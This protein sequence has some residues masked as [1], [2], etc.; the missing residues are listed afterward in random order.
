MAAPV[1][2]VIWPE[3]KPEVLPVGW[4]DGYVEVWILQD[5]NHKPVLNLQR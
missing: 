5:M 1:L 2:V 4:E 3:C